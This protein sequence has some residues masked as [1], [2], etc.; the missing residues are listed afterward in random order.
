MNALGTYYPALIG[1]A[2]IQ[3]MLEANRQEQRVFD[4]PLT[5]VSLL[6]FVLALV[7]GGLIRIFESKSVFLDFCFW[8]TVLLAIAGVWVWIIANSDNPDLKTEPNAASGGDTKR[9]L[10]GKLDGFEV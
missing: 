5:I 10:N 9:S 8:G 6:F 7:V 1:A 3:L 4:R 2:T